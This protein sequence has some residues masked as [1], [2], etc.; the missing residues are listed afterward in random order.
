[1][2]VGYDAIAE[3]T[4]RSGLPV[5][6]TWQTYLSVDER[7]ACW[8]YASRF[9]NVLVPKTVTLHV[10]SRPECRDLLSVFVSG[11]TPADF[12]RA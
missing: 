5:L 10:F 2:R 11:R 8:G 3:A 1:M 6:P 7:I 9:L 4:I 12:C